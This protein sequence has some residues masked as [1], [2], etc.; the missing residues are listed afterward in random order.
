M[1]SHYMR[2]ILAEIKKKVAS[3]MKVEQ[4]NFRQGR[5]KTDLIFTV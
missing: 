3:T 2:L 1:V 5:S 4:Q